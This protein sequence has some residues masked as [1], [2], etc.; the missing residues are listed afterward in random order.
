MSNEDLK[1][2]MQLLRRLAFKNPVHPGEKK[3]GFIF[4]N[5]DEDNKQVEIELLGHKRLTAFSFF[6]SVHEL[7]YQSLY[8]IE[9]IHHENKI[10]VDNITLRKMLKD[11][12]CCTTSEDGEKQGDPL[13][14]VFIGNADDMLPVFVRRGW[15]PAENNY[16]E[17]AKKT[18]YS[19]I[20][21]RH[22]R[23][24][25]VSPLYAFGRKQDVALQKARGTIHQ[26]QHL[27]L[28]LTPLRYQGKNVWVGQVSRDIGVRFTNKSAFLVTHK[29]DPDID[30]ARNELAQDMLFSQGLVK[31]GHV[32]GIPI[33]TPDEPAF[34]ATGDP[35]FNDGLRIVMLMSKERAPIRKLQFFNWAYFRPDA[36]H[37][38]NRQ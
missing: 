20:L 12:P 34:N 18:I 1:E 13:N 29:I 28:W 10:D 26:R 2:T 33:S 6:F 27:H 36:R 9:S 15:H 11:M 8:D 5:L 19:F 37:M 3:S 17:S 31:V 30:E 25:P 21:G 4:V 35:Y 24:S 16:L 14:L 38:D 23:Y 32:E 7:N 22:Y